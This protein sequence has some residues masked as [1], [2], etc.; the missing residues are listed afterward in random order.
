MYEKIYS[1]NGKCNCFNECKEKN[2]DVKFYSDRVKIGKFYGD[3][4]PK[5][6]FAGLEGVY[7]G[8]NYGIPEINQNSTPSLSARN[9]HYRGVRYVLSYILSEYDGIQKPK[10]AKMCDLDRIEYTNHLQYY[11]LTNIYKCAFAMQR[12]RLP[13]SKSMKN[14]CPQIFIKEIDILHPDVVI[15]QAKKDVPEQLWHSFCNTYND[16]KTPE[17]LD[18]QDGYT[19]CYQMRYED[20]TPFFVVWTYH[21]NG[22]PYARMRGGIFVNNKEYIQNQLNPVLDS[23]IQSLKSSN[24]KRNYT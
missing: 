8:P 1:C 15:I 12:S 11:C 6:L 20:G 19:S 5:I 2:N 14:N 22:F 24:D 7:D 3:R 9:E 17:R 23:L 16:G 10:S 13:H 21:G 4:Y 18:M